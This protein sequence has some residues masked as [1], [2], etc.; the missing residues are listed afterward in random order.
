VSGGDYGMLG[1]RVSR[2]STLDRGLTPQGFDKLYIII[3]NPWRL[4]IL[5]GIGV[6]GSKAQI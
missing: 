3:K 1:S 2:W 4:I 6:I 5:N